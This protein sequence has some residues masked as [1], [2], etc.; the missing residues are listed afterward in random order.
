MGPFKDIITKFDCIMKEIKY[1]VSEQHSDIPP[2]NHQNFLE[3]QACI[4][5]HI[6]H[7]ETVQQHN[8]WD[9]RDNRHASY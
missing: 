9:E 8:K 3:G 1:K 5:R 4:I 7:T 2:W 6:F